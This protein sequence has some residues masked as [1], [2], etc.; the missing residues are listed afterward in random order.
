MTE[1]PP[2]AC[3][4]CRRSAVRDLGRTAQLPQ[5][6]IQPAL[7]QQ[8]GSNGGAGTAV[9]GAVPET[10]ALQPPPH[11]LGPGHPRP[12]ESFQQLRCRL[13]PSELHSPAG[14]GSS[15][16]PAHGRNS[17]PRTRPGPAP[18]PPFPPGPPHYRPPPRESAT[19]VPPPLLPPHRD[20]GSPPGAGLGPGWASSP[21]G[22][23]RAAPPHSGPRGAAPIPHAETKRCPRA[24]PAATHRPRH[25]VVS[26]APGPDTA[27]PV[28]H[29]PT[30][31][32][33]GRAAPHLPPRSAPLPAEPRRP[34]RAA[35]RRPRPHPIAARRPPRPRPSP[36][37]RGPSAGRDPPAGGAE[38]SGGPEPPLAADGRGPGR[39]PVETSEERGGGAAG[40]SE[41]GARGGAA[42]GRVT[43][44]PALAAR[45][46]AA[47]HAALPGAA[48]PQ[49]RQ[50]AGV[51]HGPARY[52]GSAAQG[53]GIVTKAPLPA[54]PERPGAGGDG[55]AET[56]RGTLRPRAPR[57]APLERPGGTKP[58]VGNGSA[59]SR[60]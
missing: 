20:H 23:P 34:H 55:G 1:P 57:V 3:H 19:G 39:E 35:Q 12:F 17:W 21:G 45:S 16:H 52:L 15:R 30:A 8:N 47:P 31:T 37:P 43:F 28:T 44:V 58:S 48:G 40:R 38:P 32:P 5:L 49:Q 33:A 2:A 26:A 54:A 11:L 27:V 56:K 42:V 22:R 18:L 4:R 24:A 25:R 29:P 53:A 36:V 7:S 59:R 14:L 41:R 51:P 6:A 60:R 9:P 46:R 10:S 50:V 13:R